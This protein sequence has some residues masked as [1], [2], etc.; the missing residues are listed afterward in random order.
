MICHDQ[1]EKKKFAE[2]VLL[3][4]PIVICKDRVATKYCTND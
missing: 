2:N 3:N 1:P 4:A